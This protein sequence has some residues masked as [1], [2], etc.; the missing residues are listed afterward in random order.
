M[1]EVCYIYSFV[2]YVKGRIMF[3]RFVFLKAFSDQHIE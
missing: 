3:T 1:T 2:D